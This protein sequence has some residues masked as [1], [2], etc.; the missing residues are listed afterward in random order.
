MQ[1]KAGEVHVFKEFFMLDSDVYELSEKVRD[2]IIK[3]KHGARVLLDGDA[4][5]RARSAVSKVSAWDIVKDTMKGT[6]CEIVP[7][8]PKANCRVNSRID[9]VNFAFRNQLIFIDLDNCPELIKDFEMMTW[10]GEE[11]D[12]SSDEGLRSHLSD[13]FGYSV[14]RIMPY[15]GIRKPEAGTRA[16]PGLT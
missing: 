5:G 3:S 11:L 2:W 6:G 15:G 12:K 10:K 16:V 9:A 8:F 13:A 7:K 4:S 14:W 1:H